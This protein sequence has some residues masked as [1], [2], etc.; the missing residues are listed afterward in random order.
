MFTPTSRDQL[1]DAILAWAQDDPRIVGGALTGSAA[2]GKEDRWSDIDLIFGVEPADELQAVLADVTALMAADHGAVHHLDVV[3]RRTVY[4]VFFLESTLQVDL[5]F[6]PAEEFGAVAPSFK[7]LFGEEREQPQF[8]GPDAAG[9]IGWAWLYALH[10]RSSLERGKPWQAEH[11]IAGL[12]ERVLSLA[13]LRHNLPAHEGRGV[14]QLPDD[15]KA[16]LH[17]SLVG[18]LDPEALRRAFRVATEA[19]VQET[20]HADPSLADRVRGPIRALCV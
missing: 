6:A 13:C 1:R 3:A 19:L 18:T 16:T 12:R 14:D 15:L 5:A 9:L 11:M 20:E 4:R 10:A 7:L 2:L 8:P 17:D